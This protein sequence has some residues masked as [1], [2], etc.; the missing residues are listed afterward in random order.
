MGAIFQRELDVVARRPAFILSICAHVMILTAFVLAWSGGP[1]VPVLGGRVFYQQV[2]FVQAVLLT[3]ML[4][5]IAARSV[6]DE[7]GDDVVLLAALTAVRPSRLM[8]A[9]ICAVLV[10]L[11]SVVVSGLPVAVIASRMSGVP[12]S[13]MFGDQAAIMAL[14][15]IACAT[16]LGWRHVCRGRLAG[17]AI[18]GISTGALV[19]AARLALPSFAA[20]ACALATIGGVTLLVITVR[21]DRSLRYLSEHNA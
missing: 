11:S 5:W 16:S 21:S 14:V 8:L 1:E 7:R 6:A 4:P 20:T 17:W 9:R 10:A 2:R 3:I 19:V 15:L 13:R 18:A 12:I